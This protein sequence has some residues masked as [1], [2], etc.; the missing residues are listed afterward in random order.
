MEED[1]AQKIVE[2][3][4]PPRGMVPDHLGQLF[5]ALAKAQ[6]EMEVAIKDSKNPFFKSNY[7]DLCSVIKASRP[8]LSANGLSVLSFM[9]EVG[10]KT[11]FITRLGHSSGQFIDSI[12]P[13]QPPKQDIQTV[14][15]YITYLRRYAYAA[16]SGVAVSDEDDDGE[17]AM[18]RK[19]ID[20]MEKLEKRKD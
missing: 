15:S 2:M 6:G 7:A 17:N 8:H 1:N 11:Y 10:G 9:A 14:G 19:T 20:R 16:L 13:F 4:Q 12:M 5:E 3:P 18:D